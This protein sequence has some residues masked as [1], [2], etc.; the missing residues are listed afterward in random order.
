MLFIAARRALLVFVALLSAASFFT[1]VAAPLL[2][3]L[4]PHDPA[5]TQ[6]LAMSPAR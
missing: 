2:L 1:A 3:S 6:A 4:V 5:L